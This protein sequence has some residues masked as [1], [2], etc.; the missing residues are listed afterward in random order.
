MQYPIYRPRRLRANETIR[1]MVRETSLSPS[2]L[3]YPLFVKPGSGLRD[4][5]STMPGVFQLSVDQL[6]AEIDEL[7]SLGIPAV[8]LFGIPS[9]KD[10]VGS[11]AYVPRGIVQQAIRA[12]KAHDPEFYVITDVC[13]R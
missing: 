5:V 4:E 7:R 10:A 3:I 1:A 8:I 9:F 11:E 6:P 2:D 12:I 13:M